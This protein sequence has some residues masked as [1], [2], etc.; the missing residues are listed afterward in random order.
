MPEHAKAINKLKPLITIVKPKNNSNLYT[1]SENF[2]DTENNKEQTNKRKDQS[3]ISLRINYQIVNNGQTLKIYNYLKNIWETFQFDLI[4]DF[5]VDQQQ[6]YKKLF[7][8]NKVLENFITRG[9]NLTILTYGQTGSGKTCT[10]FGN[11]K[12]GGI[13]SNVTDELFSKIKAYSPNKKFKVTVSMFEL[14]NDQIKDLLNIENKREILVSQVNKKHIILKNLSEHKVETSQKAIAFIRCGQKNK[15]IKNETGSK[16]HT[17]VKLN[18][19]VSSKNSRSN[20]KFILANYIYLVDLAGS[21]E[22]L[23][24]SDNSEKQDKET[25]NIN[26]SLSSLGLMIK[27]LTGSLNSETT[28]KKSLPACKNAKLTRILQHS[29]ELKNETIL[30]LTCSTVSKNYWDTLSTLKFGERAKLL[31]K[32]DKDDHI[33]NNS[34]IGPDSQ[35]NTDMLEKV[36]FLEK[37]VDKYRLKE[38]EFLKRQKQLQTVCK[39]KNQAQLVKYLAETHHLFISCFFNCAQGKMA[40][41]NIGRGLISFNNVSPITQAVNRNPNM[42]IATLMTKCEENEKKKKKRKKN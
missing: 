13:I 42:K 3:Q 2:E 27:S 11:E 35:Y 40:F 10:M 16:L 18:C 29:L 22:L 30:I 21:E 38:L 41:G 17:L 39:N 9:K 7:Q 12:S 31:N 24:K 8:K 14:Y 1:E 33:S 5:D 6:L 4:L 36:S 34:S 15:T 19:Y 32:I 26:K 37:E 28:N 23:L 25:N 20:N